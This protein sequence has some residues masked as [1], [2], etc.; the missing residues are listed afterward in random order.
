MSSTQGFDNQLPSTR[1][2]EALTATTLSV[3]F[4]VAIALAT[5]LRIPEGLPGQSCYG[6]AS[7]LRGWLRNPTVAIY[8]RGVLSS[9]SACAN[10][11]APTPA[12]ECVPCGV[13]SVIRAEPLR[14]TTA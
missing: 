1:P 7:R 6:P 14:S 13:S 10:G 8:S 12:I 2:A 4:L 11:G 5:T 9:T 3:S